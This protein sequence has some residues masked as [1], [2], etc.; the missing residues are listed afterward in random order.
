MCLKWIREVRLTWTG[1]IWASTALQWRSVLHSFCTCSPMHDNEISS[2]CL[3]HMNRSWQLLWPDRAYS[4][5]GDGT[6]DFDRFN[7]LVL[8]PR[9]TDTWLT[10]STPCGN[11]LSSQSFSGNRWRMRPWPSP[12]TVQRQRDKS[13][14]L[15][16]F[17]TASCC[18]L[19]STNSPLRPEAWMSEI[20]M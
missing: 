17:L 19:V 7:C 2:I 4:C 18:L 12:S 13:R 16:T 8:P 20:L 15:S 6:A 11:G 10:S 1:S 5:W 3:N 14:G 9:I